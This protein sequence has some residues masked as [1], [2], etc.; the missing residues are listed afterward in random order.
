MKNG[1]TT[2]ETLV[3]C[4]NGKIRV[5]TNFISNNQFVQTVM[6]SRQSGSTYVTYNN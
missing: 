6:L 4:Q 2:I 5:Q 3:N 1:L